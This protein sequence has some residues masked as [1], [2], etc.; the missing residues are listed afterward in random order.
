M[1]AYLLEML[2]DTAKAA[3]APRPDPALYGK[4]SP[5]KILI[6]VLQDRLGA[7]VRE[8]ER[9][10]SADTAPRARDQSGLTGEISHHH[11]SFVREHPEPAGCWSCWASMDRRQRDA[12]P[13]FR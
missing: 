2:K 6:L 5:I 1:Y 3:N 10:G 7:G 11:V 8:P 4:C 9:D 13:C 12:M